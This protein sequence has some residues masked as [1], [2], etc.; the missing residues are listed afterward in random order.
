MAAACPASGFFIFFALAGAPW[1]AGLC[2]VND[3]DDKNTAMAISSNEPKKVHTLSF[4]I[5]L[6]DSKANRSRLQ[7]NRSSIT[8]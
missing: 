6:R 5:F 7:S 3:E 2:A 8:A 1:N 4:T